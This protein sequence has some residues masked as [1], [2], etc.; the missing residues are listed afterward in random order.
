MRVYRPARLPFAVSGKGGVRAVGGN[1]R[2]Y[3]VP[4]HDGGPDRNRGVISGNAGSVLIGMTADGRNASVTGMTRFEGAALALLGV[5]VA[6]L[7]GAS[8]IHPRGQLPPPA[9][10][11]IA[12]PKPLPPVTKPS[13]AVPTIHSTDSLRAYFRRIG[14]D[15][16]RVGTGAGRVPS[17]FV[18]RMPADLSQVPDVKVRKAVFL[19]SV[20]PL[21]LQVNEEILTERR[22]L[23]GLQARLLAGLSLGR[24]DSIW[25][26]VMAERYGENQI[27]DLSRRVDIIPPSLAL[28]QAAEETGWGT[29]RFARQ[30]NAIF[31]QRTYTKEGDMVPLRRDEGKTHRV[32]SFNSLLDSV[33]SY[34]LTLNSH[35]A[36]GGFRRT[37]AAMRKEDA[38]LN[39]SVLAGKLMRYSTRGEAYVKTIRVIISGNKLG[40]FDTARLSPEPPSI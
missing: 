27:D 12:L 26:A 2:Y 21:I 23:A 33:R 15:L 9:R 19:Q 20:L 38:P 36:Y 8:L 29:S 16:E 22:R 17:Y 25:L 11:S 24:V 5:L 34:A 6:A 30:G 31:G 10:V 28:A 39:G 35:W 18:S 14:Y 37:R 32:K 40:R 7:V 4:G 3:P 1:Q 13:A